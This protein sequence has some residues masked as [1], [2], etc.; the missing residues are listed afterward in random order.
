MSLEMRTG[1]EGCEVAL[2]DEG[3]VFIC[4]YRCTF[5]AGCATRMSCVC[6]N[7]WR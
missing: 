2:D 7:L 4:R 5:C 6:L 3:A 1:Y